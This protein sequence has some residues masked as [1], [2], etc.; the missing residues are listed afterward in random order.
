M[1]VLSFTTSD[2]VVIDCPQK[3]IIAMGR[4][5]DANLQQIDIDF[6]K[7]G[8][9]GVSR[10]HAFIFMADDAAYIQDYNSRN[11]TYLNQQQLYPLKRYPIQSG[12]QLTLGRITLNVHLMP[13]A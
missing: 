4:R 2:G 5:D 11:G 3:A 9:H 10:L 12:D 13:H 8:E 6:V 1:L 7:L